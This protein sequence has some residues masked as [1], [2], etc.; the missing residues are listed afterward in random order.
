MAEDANH[1]DHL[2]RLTH[3]VRDV[4]GVTDELLATSHLQQEYKSN[5]NATD[6]CIAFFKVHKYYRNQ[7]N[8]IGR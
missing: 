5:E 2:T 6:L 8:P 3:A 1:T 4:A 7:N